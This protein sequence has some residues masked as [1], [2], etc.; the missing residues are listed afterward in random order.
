MSAQIEEE[1]EEIVTYDDDELIS[2]GF[3]SA[4][5]ETEGEGGSRRTS[6][7]SV[8]STLRSSRS[9]RDHS[10]GYSAPHPVLAEGG[11]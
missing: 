6:V 9:S 4:D 8:A 10:G 7:A 5:S 1:I 2:G 11:G 3:T